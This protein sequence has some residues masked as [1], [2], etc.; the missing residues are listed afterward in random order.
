MTNRAAYNLIYNAAGF[1]EAGLGAAVCIDGMISQEFAEHVWL[2][3]RHA[4]TLVKA[5]AAELAVLDPANAAMKV[6]KSFRAVC[7]VAA[8]FT[9]VCSLAG[10]LISVVAGTPV[11]STIVA[12]DIV[13]FL[14]MSL[15][16]RVIR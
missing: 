16:G 14:F 9:V 2:S 3:L 12:A 11:G 15:I 13:A 6:A 4:A 1:V 10:I 7:I 5:I 8:V